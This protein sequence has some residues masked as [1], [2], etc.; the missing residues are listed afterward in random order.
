MREFR[1]AKTKHVINY[2]IICESEKKMPKYA[3]IDNSRQ[4]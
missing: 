1:N 3:I 2:K 4:L